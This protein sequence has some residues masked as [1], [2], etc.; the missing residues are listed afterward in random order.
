MIS[1]KTLKRIFKMK[2]SYEDI[3]CCF[4]EGIKCVISQQP[5]KAL[6]DTHYTDQDFSH[7]LQNEY[8]KLCRDVSAQTTFQK[9]KNLLAGNYLLQLEEQKMYSAMVKSEGSIRKGWL[10][11]L[12]KADQEIQ[13]L[14]GINLVECTQAQFES[15]ISVAGQL[16]V[17]R[18]VQR[19]AVTGAL[20]YI[21][22]TLFN[23]IP[24]KDENVRKFEVLVDL[25][26]NK[27]GAEILLQN[28]VEPTTQENFFDELYQVYDFE[29]ISTRR[30]LLLK[31]AKAME[32]GNLQILPDLCDRFI[33][34]LEE[35]HKYATD[36][37][38]SGNSS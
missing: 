9:Q 22:Y 26:T 35:N 24:Q 3:C 21:G 31:Y 23:F 16:A 7:V 15:A 36:F 4:E 1:K 17:V 10:G 18:L 20:V 2:H 14:A 8:N 27:L 25:H 6:V 34:S 32:T 28:A 33:N 38:S 5:I 13:R 37:F 12:L 11:V 29:E 30:Q 19:M